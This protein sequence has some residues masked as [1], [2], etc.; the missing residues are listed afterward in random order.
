MVRPPLSSSGA[1][2]YSKQILLAIPRL[3]SSQDRDETSPTYGCFD[4]EYWG[5]ATKEFSNIDVQ[6]SVFP[7]AFVWN[8]PFPGN[9]Y[10]QQKKVLTWI[11][12]G[13]L[14]WCEVQ[15]PDGSFDHL[16]PNEHSYVGAAFTLFEICKTFQ[17]IAPFMPR[18]FREKLLSHMNKAGCYL[19]NREEEHG[20]ITNHRAGAACA[21]YH[22]F[23][24]TSREAYQSKANDIINV[25][26]HRQSSEGWFYEYCGPDPGY[27]TLGINYL[28]QYYQLSGDPKVRDMLQRSISFLSYFV[29]PN[30]TIGGEYGSRV[31]ELY[32][33]GGFEIMSEFNSNASAIASFMRGSIHSLQAVH[34]TSLDHRN[35][36][37]YL[38][39]YC[40]ALRS[41]LTRR[42]TQ[43]LALLPFQKLGWHYFPKAG[44]CLNATVSSYTVIGVGRGVV[45]VFR[46]GKLVFS[47]CGYAGILANKTAV[48]TQ[49]S[50]SASQILA[51][52]NRMSFKLHFFKVPFR[53]MTPFR[54]M[55][56]RFFNYTIGRSYFFNDLIRRHLI[57]G[58]FISPTPRP[59][60]PMKRE[61]TI[62]ET[63]L[64]ILDELESHGQNFSSLKAVEKFTTILI[65][66]SKYFQQ[67]ELVESLKTRDIAPQL[68]KAGRVQ[69]KFEVD[70]LGRR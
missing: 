56:F 34:L 27:E 21:L 19:L 60:F 64:T 24:I 54:F 2:I 26:A 37:P 10:H 58:K 49:M 9:E 25:I 52:P 61:I 62:D 53:V 51:T 18:S 55:I 28:A 43:A 3:L 45:K 30:E 31:T 44:M 63:K 66:S 29:H 36:V 46:K 67:C 38:G 4:R 39:S 48:S 8:T 16:Y 65:A 47:H 5:W 70:L 23:L 40:I 14:Y 35:F 15:H 7:L 59:L 6:R 1:E 50:G 32:F 57:V 33:P 13:L 11:L 42:R 22:L 69:M 12:A 20:F 68:R 41:M 17:I